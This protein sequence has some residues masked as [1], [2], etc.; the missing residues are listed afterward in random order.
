MENV[1]GLQA[2]HRSHCVGAVL[3]ALRCQPSIEVISYNWQEGQ[4]TAQPDLDVWRKCV[5]HE[6]LLEW[7]EREAIPERLLME[8]VK[9]PAD[10]V[11]VPAFPQTEKLDDWV[12]N[13]SFPM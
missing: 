4:E 11:E 8:G 12:A 9:R 2:A 3:E 10:A 1:P 7:Q 13:G 5:D 6:G